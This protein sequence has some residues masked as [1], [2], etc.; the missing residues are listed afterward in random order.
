MD[1]DMWKTWWQ[2]DM[3]EIPAERKMRE[4]RNGK[5][6][7]KRKLVDE[8]DCKNEDILY[9]IGH[10]EQL[11]QDLLIRKR[12]CILALA[13]NFEELRE[14]GE[15]KEPLYTIDRSIYKLAQEYGL[16]VAQNWIHVILPAKYKQP[17]LYLSL[18]NA[19]ELGELLA[20]TLLSRFS[21]PISSPLVMT[22]IEEK[23]DKRAGV[24]R[25]DPSQALKTDY[26]V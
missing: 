21:S 4:N 5:E 18:Y 2:K 6:R 1:D 20:S 26:E 7:S 23:G 9:N 25:G 14:L 19:D 10:I 16:S 24:K 15:Y 12:W 8:I 3:Q 11:E 22:T 17:M 13:E